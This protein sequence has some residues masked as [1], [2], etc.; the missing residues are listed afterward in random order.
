MDGLT[1]KSVR[2]TLQGTDVAIRYFE[3][4][5]VE[6]NFI[7]AAERRS[8]IA[9]SCT[10]D[11]NVNRALYFRDI[12]IGSALLNA[13]LSR[14][15]VTPIVSR[16]VAGPRRAAPAPHQRQHARRAQQHRRLHRQ[17]RPRSQRHARAIRSILGLVTLNEGGKVRFQDIDYRVVR[18]SI[19]FQNPFRIDPLLRHR[20]RSARQRRDLRGRVGADRC[21]GR[22]SPARSTALTPTITSDPPASDITL[23]SLLG[24]G[25]L[26]RNTNGEHAGRRRRRRPL[27][28]VPVGE[29][30]ARLAARSRSST[31]S[32]S[33]RTPA[34]SIRRGDPGTKV[35]FEKRLSE[36]RCASSSSTT[37]ATP[38]TA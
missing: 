5:T 6:G 20:A 29:P 21:D 8:R 19:N 23:F 10:G 11:V 25:A 18:G 7:A 32:P 9:P 38:G 31:P 26:T 35:S 24:F 15:G 33:R 22:R 14:R 30:P 37:R 2:V 27:A 3:G 12:D 13:V 1:P 36:R 34:T 16:V 28:A 17:R 4:L